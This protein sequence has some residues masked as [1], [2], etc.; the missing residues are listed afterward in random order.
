MKSL[1]ALIVAFILSGQATALATIQRPKKPKNIILMI[2]DGM[3]LVHLYAA[4]VAQGGHSDIY[5]FAQHIGLSITASANDFI[6]DSAAGATA[7]SIG[8]KTNNGMI[9]VL[10]DSSKVETIAETAA[11]A[12]LSTGAV[13]TCELPHATPASF[14]AHQPSR[15]MYPQIVNDMTRN[16]AAHMLIGGGLPYFDTNALKTNG[17]SV[18]VGIE[19]MW[20][21]TGARQICFIDTLKEPLPFSKRGSTLVKGSA[22]AVQQLSKNKKGFFLMIEGSQIDWGAHNNDSAHVI[23]EA[24][25]FDLTARE[26][27]RWAK[28]DKNTL[29]IITA[30]HEC[31]GLTMHDFDKGNKRPTMNF[32]TG[33]HTA[34][35]VPVYAFGPGSEM[36]SGVYQNTDIYGKMM[37]LLNLKTK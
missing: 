17:Y 24:I 35:P 11:A 29:V 4:Y 28:N 33:H 31:G 22:H 19:A 10:P 36:F 5:Q 20:K 21:N 16:P 12:G 14:Y 23:D 27:L 26:M 25:D 2:G 37:N 8:K 32:S 15:K 34:E 6:T 1:A 30:D 7:I 9:G 18:S 13:V 3:G